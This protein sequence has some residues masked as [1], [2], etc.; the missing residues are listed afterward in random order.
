MNNLNKSFAKTS[1]QILSPQSS[2]YTAPAIKKAYE[3]FD[4]ASLPS[5]YLK[6]II[7]LTDGQVLHYYE[8]LNL[9][10]CLI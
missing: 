9:K 10:D 8:R 6:S 5:Q 7:L 4:D 3:V 2:T 1:V